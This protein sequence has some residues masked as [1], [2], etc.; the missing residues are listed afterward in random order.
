MAEDEEE[1]NLGI[2]DEEV[3]EAIYAE[4]AELMTES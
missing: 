4:L 3:D 2:P 1:Y